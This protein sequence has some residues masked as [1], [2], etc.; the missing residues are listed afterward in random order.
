MNYDQDKIE[1][2]IQVL[3]SPRENLDDFL[4]E[5]QDNKEMLDLYE[6]LRKYKQAGLKLEKINA[7]KTNLEWSKFE[8]KLNRKKHMLGRWMAAASIVLVA[9][10]STLLTFVYT[11]DDS[12]QM[13]QEVNIEKGNA[14][15]VLITS[16]GAEY[17]LEDGESR[18]IAD[19]SGVKIKTDSCNMLQYTGEALALSQAELAKQYNILEVPRLGEYQ[20]LL[21]D[22]T[23]VFINSESTLKYP[24]QFD[25]KQRLVEL[26]GEAYFEV[27]SK[28]DHPFIVKTNGVYTKVL[29]TEFNVCSYPNEELNITLVEGSVA[30]N[31]KHSKEILLKPGENANQIV[32]GD[33]FTVSKVDVNKYIAWRN[34]YFY[35]Q[36]ERLE[37][38]L[39]KLERWYDFKVFYQNQGVKDYRF[40]MRADRDLEFK[41]IVSRLEQTGRISIEING[42]IIVVADVSRKKA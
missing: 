2:V 35:F 22:G 12:D 15:A 9:S 37:D 16:S 14:R 20:I 19:R 23:K 27:K 5:Y 21:S 41:S 30:L 31:Q 8:S 13:A 28:P 18:I 29:G 32:E 24:V 42:N 3:R 40:K 34:G 17:K 36:K 11:V 38:I 39:L 7:P 6:E 10:V 4:N 26:T 33:N 1:V 25:K